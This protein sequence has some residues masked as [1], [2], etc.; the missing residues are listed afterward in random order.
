MDPIKSGPRFIR[1]DGDVAYVP[2]SKG[3]EVVIDAADVGLIEGPAW[4]AVVRSGGKNVYASRFEWTN[5]ARVYVLMHRLILGAPRGL[6]VDHI[7][8]NGLNNRRSNLRIATVAQ[9]Q[10]N[11]R[12][13]VDN[14]SGVRG[15]H[16]DQSSRKWAVNIRAAGKRHYLGMFS[17]IDDAAAA[18]A[19]ASANLHGEFGRLK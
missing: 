5:K 9:N 14:A 19:K 3:Y 13:R 18:Y 4:R 7:D 16:W 15:V 10:Q 17:E 2:I 11:G 6:H 8:G 1:I 12:L